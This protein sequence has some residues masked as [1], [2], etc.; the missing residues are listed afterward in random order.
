MGRTFLITGANVGI[1]RVAT[2]RLASEGGRVFLA[3]RSREKAM[4]VV[5]GIRARGGSAEFLPLEL[6]DFASIRACAKAFLDRGEPLHVLVNNAGI[7]GPRG[8]TKQGFELTVGTNH[9]G[10]FLLTQLLLPKLAEA[11]DPRV[12]NV[13]SASHYQAKAIDWDDFKRPTSFTALPEYAVS[14]L[15]NVLFTKELARRQEGKVRAFSL[16]PGTVAT[17][18]WSARIPWGFRHLMKLFMTTEE[19]GAKTTVHC[20]TSPDVRDGAY[21]TRSREKRPSRLAEDEAL[22][23]ELWRRSEEWVGP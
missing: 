19:D 18:I 4:P 23:K 1:G 2:E 17:N 11:E 8:L 12:V 20:A 6:D 7:A 15:C 16:H 21:Y 14:K 5:E 13:A 3:C 10:P 9:L 22:A